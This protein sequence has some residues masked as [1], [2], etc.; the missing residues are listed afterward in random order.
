MTDPAV[1]A[2]PALRRRLS[3]TPLE[4]PTAGRAFTMLR[5]LARLRC[6]NCGRGAVLRRWFLVH[7]RCSACAFRYERSDE[8]YF[9]GAM[10][11]NYMLGGFT[12]AASFLAV[13]LF[14]WPNVPWNTLTYAAPPAFGVF[15]V[16]FYPVSK[17]VWLT[18]DVTLR[19]VMVEELE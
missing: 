6:P 17:V 2:P 15:M 4:M 1:P 19:P 3:D 13:L 11:V 16:A 5:R 18:A 7:E 14:S 8:N 10:F 12:F 9:Q